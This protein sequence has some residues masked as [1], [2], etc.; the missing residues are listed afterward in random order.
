VKYVLDQ[1]SE[2]VLIIHADGELNADVANAF[3][4]QI[5]ELVQRGVT[6][7]IIDFTF[8]D[9]ISSAGI[10]QVLRLHKRAAVHGGQVKLC[11]IKGLIRDVLAVSKLDKVFEIYRDLDEARAAMNAS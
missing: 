8:V 3:V 10:F 11:S 6:K 1:D 2:G 9:F 7:I 5:D 4:A